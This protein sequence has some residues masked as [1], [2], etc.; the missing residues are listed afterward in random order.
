MLYTFLFNSFTQVVQQAHK[1]CAERRND[2][3]N[4]LLN[5]NKLFLGADYDGKRIVAGSLF[6]GKII[7]AND[8]VRNTGLNEVAE[9]FTRKD[10]GLGGSKKAQAAKISSLY[11]SVPSAG[12][13]LSFMFSSNLKFKKLVFVNV[14]KLFNVLYF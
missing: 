7:L 3:L 5:L 12:V 9:Y 13:N 6:S 4:F 2:G 11:G 14:C 8:G 1:I 10:N